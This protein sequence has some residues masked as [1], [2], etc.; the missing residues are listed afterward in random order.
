MFVQKDFDLIRLRWQEAREF[1][2]AF[3]RRAVDWQGLVQGSQPEVYAFKGPFDGGEP[4]PRLPTDHPG[5]GI[6]PRTLYRGAQKYRD[7]H[8][9]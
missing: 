4:D 7:T 5:R 8:R 6:D 3:R 9:Q 1:R 2:G